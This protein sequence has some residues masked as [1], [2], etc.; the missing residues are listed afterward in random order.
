MQ[1]I[2]ELHHQD[3]VY[4]RLADAEGNTGKAMNTTIEDT[5]EPTADIQT[6]STTIENDDA[7]HNGEWINGTMHF[8]LVEAQ[9]A[10]S[11]IKDIYL[12]SDS[13]GIEAQALPYTFAKE[14]IHTIETHVQDWAGNDKMQTYTSKM[15]AT[16]PSILEITPSTTQPTK[17]PITITAKAQDTISGIQAYKYEYMDPM[18]PLDKSN[19]SQLMKAQNEFTAPAYTI[20][21]NGTYTFYVADQA[22]NQ[23]KQTIK[24]TNIIEDETRITSISA[25]STAYIKQ[26]QTATYTITT[27][28]P[29][30]LA[31]QNQITVSGEGSTG[32]TVSIAGSGTTWT[33]TVTA[34]NGNGPVRLELRSGLFAEIQ[35]IQPTIIIQDGLNVDNIAPIVTI[36]PASGQ[37]TKQRTILISIEENGAGLLEQNAYSYSLSPDETNPFAEGSVQGQYTVNTPFTIGEGLNGTYYLYIPQVKDKAGNGS[38][39]EI[40]V[41]GVEYYTV[42]PYTFEQYLQQGAWNPDKG[43]NSPY[44]DYSL[45]PIIWVNGEEIQKYTKAGINPEWDA[46]DGDEKWYAYQSRKRRPQGEP[47]GKC[48]R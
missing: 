32:A 34:G 31:H 43:V 7:I 12:K 42:G 13:A 6:V 9:D 8:E 41:E 27:N 4:A 18:H 2:E 48:G 29:V 37:A 44:M 14:G 3:S 40:T 36:S 24:I 26:G 35:D 1:E 47:M 45:N 15:D 20:T 21:K 28:H 39:A 38:I 22:G 10:E 16:A 46:N 25:P 33:A 17:E 30:T 11:G 23:A 5:V 19:W